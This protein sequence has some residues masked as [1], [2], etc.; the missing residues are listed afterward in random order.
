[1]NNVFVSSEIKDCEVI[2]IKEVNGSDFRIAPTAHAHLHC[3]VEGLASITATIAAC[4]MTDSIDVI[5][6]P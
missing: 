4:V 3:C 5:K 2:H 1:M 6:C